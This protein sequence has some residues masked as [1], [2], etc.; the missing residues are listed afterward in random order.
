MREGIRREGRP[1]R[2]VS[3]LQKLPKKEVFGGRSRGATRHHWQ[4]LSDCSANA[5]G[6]EEPPK[7]S[8]ALDAPHSPLTTRA[9]R[10]SRRMPSRPTVRVLSPL[11][12]HR[13]AWRRSDSH[14]GRG[15]RSGSELRFRASGTE[16]RRWGGSAW[17]KSF[18]RSVE[19][20]AARGV[21]RAS[22]LWW[23]LSTEQVQRSPNSKSC[24]LW[25][26]AS[27]KGTPKTECFILFLKRARVGA[28]ERLSPRAAASTLSPVPFC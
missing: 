7:R 3:A 25:R 21:K 18:R 27:R 8:C 15:V 23:F 11:A 1:A 12:R 19:G 6:R 5:H 24:Q 14:H 22:S 13:G 9:G 17:G 26:V 20:A 4:R 10:P 28:P 2:W 16:A